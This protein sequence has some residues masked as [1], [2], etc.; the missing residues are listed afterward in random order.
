MQIMFAGILK[1]NFYCRQNF[2]LSD[3]V[4]GCGFRFARLYVAL[5]ISDQGRNNM[6]MGRGGVDGG[7]ERDKQL[8]VVGRTCLY[9]SRFWTM[10]RVVKGESLQILT[11]DLYKKIE[12]VLWDKKKRVVCT[13]LGGQ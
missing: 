11:N 1:N 9:L 3:G 8:S 6:F 10:G 4:K 5:L 12:M 2:G 7:R 13:T